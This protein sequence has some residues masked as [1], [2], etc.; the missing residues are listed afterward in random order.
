M[1]EDILP[2]TEPIVVSHETHRVMVA[3]KTLALYPGAVFIPQ[4]FLGT[5][6]LS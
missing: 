4:Y 2:L 1:T 3:T 5:A 6:E